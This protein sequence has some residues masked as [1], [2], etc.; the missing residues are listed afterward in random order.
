VVCTSSLDLGVDFPQ[1]SRLLEVQSRWSALPSEEALLIERVQSREGSHLFDYPFCGRLANEG[2]ATLVAARWAR[3][4][5][6]TF[7]VGANDYGFELLSATPIDVSESRLRAAL[8]A[9]NLA[10]DLR[11]GVA[12]QLLEAQA[13]RAA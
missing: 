4:S 5:A 8:S 11:A 10:E 9:D 6:Q 7:A 1:V 13:A 2:I 12:A 3:E